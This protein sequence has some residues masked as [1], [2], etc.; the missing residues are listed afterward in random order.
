MM[1]MPQPQENTWE[2]IVEQLKMQLSNSEKNLL[3][4]KAQLKEAES[5]LPNK[6]EEN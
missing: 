4:L 3:M 1:G 5:H 6:S 2:G